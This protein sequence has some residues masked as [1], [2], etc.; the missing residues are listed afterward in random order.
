MALDARTGPLTAPASR[1]APGP[2][3]RLATAEAMLGVVGFLATK[4]KRTW[5]GSLIGRFLSPLLFLLSMGLGLGSL[6]DSRSGGIDGQTYL[7]FVVPGIVVVQA[8][9]IAVGESTYEVM[10]YI[11]WNKM[12]AAMLATPLRVREVLAGHLL[13]VAAHLGLGTAIFVAVASLF[14]S[15]GSWAALWCLP[16]GVLTGLAFAVPIFAFTGTQNGDNGFNILFRLVV[17]PLMLFSGT[18]FPVTQ[19]PGWMRPL[20]WATPLWHG[21]ELSRAAS[22]GG[23]GLWPV[24]LHVVVLLAFVAVGWVLAVRVFSRRLVP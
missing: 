9:W 23:L 17:T 4:Y 12:Y 15:F 2:R 24:V 22:V 20:A 7:H 6:V 21:V 14:G 18:F 11:K 8:M 19:L 16:V 1:L 13:T 3:P 10:G 5:R